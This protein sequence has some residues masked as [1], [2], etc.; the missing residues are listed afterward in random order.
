MWWDIYSVSI[1]L[2]SLCAGHSPSAGD[3][4]VNETWP[5][6]QGALP[7]RKT[8]PREQVVGSGLRSVQ[9]TKALG[10]SLVPVPIIRLG[11]QD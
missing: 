7:S 11:L 10:M 5:R 2:L 8:D 6:P 1:H 3:T 9:Q 4:A